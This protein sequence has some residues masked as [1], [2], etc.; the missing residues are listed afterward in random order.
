M[1]PMTLYVLAAVLF[2]LGLAAIGGATFGRQRNRRILL[3]VVGVALWAVTLLLYSQAASLAPSPASATPTPTA[4]PSPLPNEEPEPTAVQAETPVTVTASVVLPELPGQVAFHSD[5]DGEIDI[6]VMN[7]D[8]S[9]IR[10]LTDAPG[11]DFEPDWSPDGQTIVF[12]SDRDDPDNAQLYLMA[13][14][15]SNQR[16]LPSPL[17]DDQVGARWSPD[18]QWILFHSNPLVDALPRFDVFKVRPDGSDLTQLTDVPGNSFMADWSPD[19]ERIVFVT[20]R[21]GNSELYVM[22]ADGTNQVRLTE[23]MTE[24]FLPRWSPDGRQILFESNRIGG[25]YGL[26]L[27]DAPGASDAATS[28]EDTVRQ[29]T[30]PGFNNVTGNW[31]G[32]DWIFFSSDRDSTNLVNWEIYLMTADGSEVFRVTTSP[33]LDRFPNWRP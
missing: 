18:G 12:S 26:Y 14:D 24:N 31:A 15:G 29:L 11:R 19:G 32:D 21:H 10:R 5:R 20:Q 22:N 7:A 16:R 23:G 25:T 13:A 28:P 3:A 4:Q 33:G 2:V 30:L 6:Y 27:I 1:N 9:D 8:G 17:A